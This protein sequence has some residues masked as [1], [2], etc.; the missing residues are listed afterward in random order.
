MRYAVTLCRNYDAIKLRTSQTT[1][2]PLTHE[3]V[4]TR[5]E[6]N[7]RLRQVPSDMRVV[8]YVTGRIL[9][10]TKFPIRLPGVTVEQVQRVLPMVMDNPERYE[11]LSMG[12]IPTPPDERPLTGLY[13]KED[14]ANLKKDL[15]QEAK[16]LAEEWA[17]EEGWE[18]DLWRA[19]EAR[20]QWEVK[21]PEEVKG[22]TCVVS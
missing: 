19:E 20:K 11:V 16:K 22:S 2:E 17:Q 6:I 21:V 13:L 3:Y 18:E 1:M 14:V 4:V 7:R 10:S 5:Q 9:E 12:N 15:A 8:G